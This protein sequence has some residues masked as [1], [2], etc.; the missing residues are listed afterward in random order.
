MSESRFGGFVDRVTGEDEELLRLQDD[1]ERG[2]PGALELDAI[3]TGDIE[4]ELD[5]DGGVTVD[6]DPS[7]GD[8]EEG[9]FYRNLAEDVDD[10]ELGSLSSDLMSQ[11]DSNKASRSDW[12]DSYSK[13]LEL[14]GFNYE[15][16][17]MPFRGASGVTHPLLAEAAIQFQAQ[18]FNELL[19]SDGPVKTQVFGD[20]SNGQVQQ[21]N[22]VKEFMNYY[23]MNVMKEY[24][25]DFDQMLFYLPL[26]GS[27]F[28]KVY[29]DEVLERAVSKFV[30]AE[31]LV[32]PYETSDLDSCPI[33]AQVLRMPFNELRKKQVAGFYRDIPVLP[34]QGNNDLGSAQE[35]YDK[36]QGTSSSQIDYDCTL[37]EFHVD[38]DLEGFE[39]LDEDGEPTGIKVPYIVTVSEDSGVILSIR[40]NFV[41]DDPKR[42]KI[43]YF[44]HYKFLPGFGFYGLGL[45]HSIGG[46][47]RTATAA[48]RQLIDAGTFSNLPAG[49]KARGL[50]VRNEDEPLQ[51]G[52][53]R[54]VDAP[55][56]VLR[57]SLMPLPFKGPDATLF[58]LLGFVVDAGRRFA[59]ITDMK[60][61]DGNQ[62][63]AVGTTI[64][65]LEQGSRVMSAVH[66]RLHYAMREEFKLLARIMSEYL[67]SEY[68]YMV[69]GAQR[70]VKQEDFDD[71]ID[72][73]PVSDP[74]VFSQSQRIALAQA[75][76][77]L[78]TQAPELHDMH[79]AYRRMYYALGVRDVDKILK[80]R[81]EET[82]IPKDPAQENID[83]L[84]SAILKAY[85]GQAH[86]AHIQ[87]HLTF[88]TSPLVAQMPMVGVN[89]LKH[90]LEHVKLKAQ[91][92]AVIQFLQQTGGEPASEEQ[93]L[94]LEALESQ[95]IAQGMVEMKQ[96]SAQLSGIGQ[97]QGPD[98]L[99]QLKEQELQLKAQ[100]AQQDAQQE[101]AELAL[102]REKAQIK[103][104]EFQQRL[105]SQESQTQQR[106]QASL[107]RELLKQ[108][109]QR[110]QAALKGD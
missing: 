53:F 12:E 7:E 95:L 62:Q 59:T 50:R 32:V 73:I 9:D 110:Q 55:G 108:D 83:A 76:L 42:E 14:L 38:L 63:A 51:P 19:P 91:E 29:Y 22:R 37:I 98:P 33:I 34:S 56:G 18:A 88:A 77:Q 74:N 21:A 58:Q 46:L 3:T 25:P 64:A 72:V 78:A 60:V 68:P 28:K 26:A 23:I 48:L 54:D 107:Q 52:E 75:E 47:S 106:L 30:P 87:A 99:V 4:I 67:P 105:Q 104:Q 85:E 6:F 79:E 97:N 66:K 49:F 93:M 89:L 17:T 24:T 15:E 94:E 27:T 81:A 36:I 11:Y 100:E 96:L 102:Q 70:S 57:D 86:D 92:Q 20:T 39:E 13:G 43:Q 90:V 31:N 65:M 80:P 5:E 44:V 101:Q 10:R 35:E 40:R 45:I 8:G 84:D 82:L 69:A 103:A 1:A 16:R 41:E 61:G 71:R 109:F 2:I